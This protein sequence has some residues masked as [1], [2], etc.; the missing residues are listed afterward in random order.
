MYVM[1]CYVMLCYVMYVEFGKFLDFDN[2]KLVETRGGED[3]GLVLPP[4]LL[5]APPF[6]KATGYRRL[7]L[8][9]VNEGKLL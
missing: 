8:C 5:P 7:A 1:L 9:L 3:R 4:Q 6:R 2:C